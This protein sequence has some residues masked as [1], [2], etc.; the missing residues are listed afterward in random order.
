MSTCFL[1]GCIVGSGLL[2]GI[3]LLIITAIKTL[4]NRNPYL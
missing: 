2:A 4:K 1:V 3:V